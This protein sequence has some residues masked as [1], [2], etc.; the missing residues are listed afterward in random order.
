MRHK[1]GNKKLG[2]PTDQRMAMLKNIV[3]ALFENN[4]IK[5]TDTRAKEAKKIAEKIITL[6]KNGDLSSIR[7]ALKIIPN[8]SVIK[9]VFSSFGP[10]YKDRNGGYTRIIK[11]GFRKGDNAPVSLLE[12][13]E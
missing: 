12:L 13:V 11:L 6:G 10:K 2:K 5:T 3:V 8:K 1:R 9:E 7:K 4:R